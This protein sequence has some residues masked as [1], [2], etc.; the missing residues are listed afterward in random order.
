MTSWDDQLGRMVSAK[1][2]Q[3]YYITIFMIRSA[4]RL[5]AT[6]NDE[7]PKNYTYDWVG[8]LTTAASLLA[9]PCRA[10]S[11]KIPVNRESSREFVRFA[12]R[13]RRTPRELWFYIRGL[14]QNSHG[15]RTGNY[16][17]VTGN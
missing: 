9:F 8:R 3:S 5:K 11:P 1:G 15:G 4:N 16:F 2:P 7:E 10:A 6:S 13:S 14:H 17:R 12:P